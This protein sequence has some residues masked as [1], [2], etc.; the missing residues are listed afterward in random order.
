[1]KRIVLISISILIFSFSVLAQNQNTTDSSARKLEE[2][3]N[4]VTRAMRRFG[5]TLDFKDV[6]REMFIKDKTA[7]RHLFESEL[8]DEKLNFTK[9]SDAEL[10]GIYVREQNNSWLN[11]IY[12]FKAD[13]KGNYVL[14][15]ENPD[16]LIKRELLPKL[17][18]RQR[19]LYKRS[20]DEIESSKLPQ[21]DFLELLN[22]SDVFAFVIR[23]RFPKSLKNNLQNNVTVHAS[24]SADVYY[25]VA[26]IRGVWGHFSFTVVEENGAMKIAYIVINDGKL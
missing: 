26:E 20:K 22:I 7:K 8:E 12:F 11:W 15:H 1:M 3:K 17:T 5:Q 24:V 13:E 25:V 18:K 21:T 16:E 14:D 9:F 10:E 6:F 4:L 19:I 2:A 23:K